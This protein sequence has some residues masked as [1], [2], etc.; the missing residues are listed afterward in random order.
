[1]AA[2]TESAMTESAMAAEPA[3]PAEPSRMDS[4]EDLLDRALGGMAA[5]PAAATPT[6][7]EA[8]AS[9]DPATLPETPDRAAVSRALGGLMPR[10]RQC[11]GEQVGM[12]TARIRVANDGSVASVSIGG[13]P[14]G[15]TPQGTC[16]EGVVQTARFPRFR[17][18]HFDVTYP[19]AIRPAN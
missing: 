4:M 19:F 11:A 5:T 18:S 1:M 6:A 13:S 14:F 12:A 16:M 10:I 3:T 15:G 17:Q 8:T 9:A 7:M 2:A